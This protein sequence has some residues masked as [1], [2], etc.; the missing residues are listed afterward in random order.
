[1]RAPEAAQ[2]AASNVSFSPS[3]LGIVSP[4]GALRRNPAVALSAG[5]V[6]V[7]ALLVGVGWLASLHSRVAM[8]SFSGR[9]TQVNLHVSSGD[10]VIVGSSSST[11]EVRRTDHYSFGHPAGEHRSYASGLLGITSGC[12]RIVVGSCSASYEL[13]VPETV[14]VTVQTTDGSVRLD[15]FQGDAAVQTG[16]GNVDAEA[17]CGFHLSA[18]SGSGNLHVAAACAPEHLQLRT[19]SGD[20]VALVPPGRYRIN[21]SG[22]RR[23]VTGVIP[24]RSAPFTIDLGSKSG[25]VTVQG[26]L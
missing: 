10:V 23:Q 16:S 15:G 11:V 22:A 21:A 26:G 8:Y 19:G 3:A 20:A 2:R 18:S 12:P 13:A 1:M 6:I 24:D 5:I 7:V 9:L 25:G 14:F 4:R 17:Y